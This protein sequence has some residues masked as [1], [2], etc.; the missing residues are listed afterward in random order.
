MSSAGCSRTISIDENYRE[1]WLIWERMK[2]GSGIL[3]FLGEPPGETSSNLKRRSKNDDGH[4][5]LSTWGF[6][7]VDIGSTRRIGR[8]GEPICD[9]HDTDATRTIHARARVRDGLADFQ[10]SFE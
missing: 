10:I 9:G 2:D 7:C 6:F 5:G 3:S 1:R 4:G 8:D